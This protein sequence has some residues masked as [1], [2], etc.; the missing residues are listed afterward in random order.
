ML[1]KVALLLT[2]EC[3]RNWGILSND[4]FKALRFTVV[5][6]FFKSFLE[7]SKRMN[8]FHKK[9]VIIMGDKLN[10]VKTGDGDWMKKF[11]TCFFCSVVVLIAVE[12]LLPTKSLAYNQAEA[13]VQEGIYSYKQMTEDIDLLKEKYPFLKVQILKDTTRGNSVYKIKLGAGK[14]SV[15][16]TNSYMAADWTTTQEAMA[17]LEIYADAYANDLMINEQ[18]IRA[19]LD[20]TSMIFIPTTT[21]SIA[22]APRIST[23]SVSQLNQKFRHDYIRTNTLRRGGSALIGPKFIVAHDTGN[24][25]STAKNNVDYYKRSANSTSASAHIFVDNK[26]SVLTVPL[27]EK[28]WHV[29]YNVTT[30]NKLFGYNANDAAIGVELCYFSK[31]RA[32][33]LKA[34]RN[35]VNVLSYLCKTYNLDPTTDIVSHQLLDPTRRTDPT[36][37][38]KRIGKTYKNLIQDVTKNINRLSIP[39][40]ILN[41]A[42]KENYVY[43]L[44]LTNDNKSQFVWSNNDQLVYADMKQMATEISTSL[45]QSLTVS[46]DARYLLQGKG[47]SYIPQL[48]VG[49]SPEPVYNSD[50]QS[51]SLNALTGFEVLHR[52]HKMN[53]IEEEPPVE[54]E[55]LEELE[56]LEEDITAVG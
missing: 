5:C 31:D 6:N 34:Y 18:N 23:M 28:A 22:G 4:K 54:F 3:T 12:G 32:R 46:K 36:N 30:D 24:N 52:L 8:L 48:K 33:S 17:L 27:T 11:F 49:I 47:S 14:Q 13:I 45:N 53:E 9:F 2:F 7:N 37:A 35:Y 51:Y 21:T 43:N 15:L 1:L 25:N 42:E 50:T 20:E 26:E 55:E 44:V 29:R 10:Y 16:V 19:L 56:P 38:L 39:F 41:E 40:I